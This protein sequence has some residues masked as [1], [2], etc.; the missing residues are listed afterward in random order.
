[1]GIY[2][3][4]KT[5]MDRHFFTLEEYVQSM[6]ELYKSP[7]QGFEN[8]STNYLK[9]KED[10]ICRIIEAEKIVEQEEN[11]QKEAEEKRQAKLACIA[12]TLL[13]RY[14]IPLPT[15]VIRFNQM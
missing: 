2:P 4:V 5:V 13:H 9:H 15:R 14:N 1:M 10:L 7:Q 3:S 11:E 6:A 12:S 8:L